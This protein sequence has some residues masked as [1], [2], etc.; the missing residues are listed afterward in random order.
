[1][2]KAIREMDVNNP[3]SVDVQQIHASM[4]EMQHLI[5]DNRGVWES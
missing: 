4:I 2:R 5:Y 1:M 3:N